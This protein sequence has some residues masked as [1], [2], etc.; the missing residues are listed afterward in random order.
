ME[1]VQNERS[2]GR[3]LSFDN[4]DV[5]LLANLAM[6]PNATVVVIVPSGCEV[7]DRWSIVVHINDVF[8]P[9]YLE[10]FLVN[11]YH[12]VG[13]RPVWKNCNVGS[14]VVVFVL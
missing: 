11:H 2:S 6:L 3:A 1:N 14:L 7:E 8:L 5:E 9:A 12:V 4:F 10:I 13:T